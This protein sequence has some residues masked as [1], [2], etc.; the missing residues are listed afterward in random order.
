MTPQ[1]FY[2]TT[3]ITYANARPH[4]G[5]AYEEIGTDA[6]ARWRR[7]HGDEVWFATGS[8]E[9]SANVESKAKELGITPL[10]YCDQ[11]AEIFQSTWKSLNISYDRFIRTS[12]PVHHRA[13]QEIVRRAQAAGDIYKGKY[14]GWYCRSCENYYQ[15]NELAS[16]QCPVHGIRPVWLSEEN[17]FFRLSRHQEALL[18]H[19]ETHPEYI[20]P[21]TRRNEILNLLKAGLKDISISRSGSAWGIPFP[22]DSNQIIYVWFDAL[23]NYLSALGFPDETE[24]FAKFWPAEVHVIGKDITRFH[25]I[26]WGA[27]LLSAGL[28][29]P[30]RIFGHGFIYLKGEKIS[31]TRG[32]VLDPLDM[33]GAYGV[34]PFRYVLLSGN[35]FA[36]D[37]NFSE[38][39]L[40]ER[41]NSDLANDLGNL[42]NRTLTMAEK[43]FAGRV[44]DGEAGAGQIARVLPELAQGLYPAFSEAM[45]NFDFSLAAGRVMELV[46][47]ANKLIEET[48]PWML[49]KENRLEALGAVMYQLL[50]VLR[51]SAVYLY[52][53]MPRTTARIL[54]QLGDS[55]PEAVP[56]FPGAA[57]WGGL[58]VGQQ[59]RKAQPLFPRLEKK[60]PAG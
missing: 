9:H 60:A 12:E 31:K 1:K 51:L 3:A 28:P 37:G 2:L 43:Y 58:A 46:R 30:Q 39:E 22:G 44:P 8:D 24:R 34:D 35:H 6:L 11:M 10:A 17:Y 50:E 47:R 18:R 54:E 59:T 26:I 33:A 57:A 5:H 52:P 19:V 45:R 23:I 15:E 42:L 14:E 36:A 53:F 20:Q 29:L 41:Y 49:A 55:R 7:L 4:L 32:N 56:R 27:M 38:A 16:G 25:A 13:S 40:I 48:A 21:E